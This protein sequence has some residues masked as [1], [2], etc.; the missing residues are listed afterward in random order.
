[1][2]YRRLGNSGLKVSAMTL[3][4][5]ATHGAQ[6][7]DRQ[8]IA[9]VHAA[10]DIGI[11]TFDT[12]DAYAEGRAEVLLGQALA[13]QD[14]AN[15]EILTKVFWP[16]GPGPNNQGLSRKHILSAVDASLRRLDVDY[17]DVYQAH[18]FDAD[19]PMEETLRAFDDLVRAGKVL[20]VG[21][22]EWSADQIRRATVIAD[23]MGLD[24]V[25]SN[26]PQYSLLWRV[27]EDQITPTCADLGIG[28]I[29][30]SP[31]AQGMLTGKYLPGQPPPPHSRATDPD[32]AAY[33][34]R[35]MRDEVL[36][37]VQG[38]APIAET[39]GLTTAQLSLA[40]VLSQPTICSAIVGASNPDQLRANALAV[41]AS[42]E[43]DTLTDIENVMAGV[44]IL[45]RPELPL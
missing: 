1:M 44:A 42:L 12:A 11:T 30:W 2:E 18:R 6:I 34:S 16:M 24:R 13:G 5:W 15:L 14:R 39:L 19:V 27:I 17:I 8:A 4:N 29:V 28:Q 45:E 38:L 7:D 32:G 36:T 9:T 3:G 35:W 22:S 10:L 37:A 41:N 25:I 20:Y 43:P 40:W 23:E 31:L 33:I 21:V 26:Q